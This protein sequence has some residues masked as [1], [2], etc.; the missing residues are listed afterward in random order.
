MKEFHSHVMTKILVV[1]PLTTSIISTRPAYAGQ[2]NNVA[3]ELR[4]TIDDPASDETKELVL[5]QMKK[6]IEDVVGKYDRKS[7]TIT[8]KNTNSKIIAGLSGVIRGKFE[9]HVERL[10]VDENYRSQGIGTKMIKAVENY[11]RANHCG[12]IILETM[13]FQAE[14]FYSKLGFK[15]IAT[16]PQGRFGRDQHVMRKI[17]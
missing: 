8:V 16:I 17:L 12:T 11:A 14:G 5:N 6:T 10:W 1:I 4:L 9:C 3:T 7:F 15:R 13:D 2:N